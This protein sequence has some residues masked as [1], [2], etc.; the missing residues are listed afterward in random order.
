MEKRIYQRLAEL[1]IWKPKVS[2]W[3]DRKYEEIEAIIRTAPHGS[4]I[5]GEITLIESISTASMIVIEA[6]YH[7]MNQNGYYGEWITAIITITATL[8]SPGLKIDVIFREDIDLLNTYAEED[9]CA[10]VIK[11][12]PELTGSEWEDRVNECTNYIDE[13]GIAEYI[14]ECFYDWFLTEYKEVK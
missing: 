12:H 4:G 1:I 3:V 9:A 10:F 13:D 5:D 2:K 14:A 6:Q 11:N 8:V 7:T